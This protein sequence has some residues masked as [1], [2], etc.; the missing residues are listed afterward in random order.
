MERNEGRDIDQQRLELVMEEAGLD[1]KIRDD[2]AGRAD[3]VL[4]TSLS[5]LTSGAGMKCS[6][7]EQ[8]RRLSDSERRHRDLLRKLHAAIGVHAADARI[9][10]CNARA[11][12]ML[13]L[14]PDQFQVNAALEP[15]WCFINEQGVRMHV[16]RLSGQPRAT[17]PSTA[18]SRGAGRTKFRTM[19]EATYLSAP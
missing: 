1:R 4:L 3:T 10:Y 6:S 18:R 2:Y 12:E 11:V 16:A 13:G 17:Q 14:T 5:I 15:A 7:T 9:G 8:Q 19:L